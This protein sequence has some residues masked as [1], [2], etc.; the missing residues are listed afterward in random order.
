MNITFIVET[1]CYESEWNGLAELELARNEARE[2]VY[3]MGGESFL[4]EYHN[5]KLVKTIKF[6]SEGGDGEQE[7]D[8]VVFETVVFKAKK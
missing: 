4:H 7:T 2:Y 8:E 1:G 6:E 5:D 3:G